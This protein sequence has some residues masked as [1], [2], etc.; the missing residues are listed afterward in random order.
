M[1]KT[2]TTIMC[3]SQT[4]VSPRTLQSKPFA[5]GKAQAQDEVCVGLACMLPMRVQRKFRWEAIVVERGMVWCAA[6]WMTAV[7]DQVQHCDVINAVLT[8]TKSY[9]TCAAGV[10]DHGKHHACNA[11]RP[12]LFLHGEF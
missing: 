1:A 8:R 9:G 6:S 10:R 7:R 5:R 4:P 12:T 11:A 2:A 3:L